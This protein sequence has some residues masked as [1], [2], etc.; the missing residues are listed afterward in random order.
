MSRILIADRDEAI[1]TLLETAVCRI[2][3]CEVVLAHDAATAIELLQSQPFDLVLL[4]ISMHSDGLQTLEHVRSGDASC[5]VIA[6]TTG[7]IQASLVQ[8]LAAANV[9]AV[10]PKPFDLGQLASLVV[11]S[12]HGGRTSAHPRVY[13]FAGKNPTLD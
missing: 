8:R 3:A 5:E 10:V 13:R 11:E 4:D 9:F 6:L 1:A 12:I 2:P 7:V